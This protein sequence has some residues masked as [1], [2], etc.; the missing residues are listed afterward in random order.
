MNMWA[1]GISAVTSAIGTGVN[2]GMLMSAVPGAGAFGTALGVGAGVASLG[3]GIGD[4]IAQKDMNNK[5]NQYMTTQYELNLGNVKAQP[6]TIS[7]ITA[8]NINTKLFPMIYTYTCTEQEQTMV[9]NYFKYNGMTI[10]TCGKV[11]DYVDVNNET[12]VSARIIR[13]NDTGSTQ[14]DYNYLNNINTELQEGVY[15]TWQA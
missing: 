10:N 12:F 4:L 9:N 3:A 5:A 15:V 8:Y 1:S 7:K 2:T 13:W 11:E 6:S 14:S